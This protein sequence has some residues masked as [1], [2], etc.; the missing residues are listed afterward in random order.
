MLCLVS[1]GSRGSLGP[2]CTAL[3]GPLSMHLVTPGCRL[4]VQRRPVN[5]SR[6]AALGPELSGE[7]DAHRPI[8]PRRG[9]CGHSEAKAAATTAGGPRS[10]PLPGWLPALC[11]ALTPP[12][13]PR[14]TG[15]LGCGPTQAQGPQ[16]P[17]RLFSPPFQGPQLRV[18]SCV[19]HTCVIG[20]KQQGPTVFLGWG[21]PFWKSRGWR[22]LREPVGSAADAG[23]RFRGLLVSVMV[24]GGMLWP[25]EPRLP[26]VVGGRR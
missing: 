16:P 1:A 20:R 14:I 8:A 17:P 21:A 22:T 2:Q 12:G 10:L 18:C 5:R 25:L 3:E 4:A 9:A 19:Q 26:F 15:G 11:L 13:P 6:W 24:Q 7:P 23:T